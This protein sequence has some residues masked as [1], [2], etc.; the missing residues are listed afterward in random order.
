[1]LVYLL[2]GISPDIIRRAS[3]I[4]ASVSLLYL[5]CLIANGNPPSSNDV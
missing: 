3:T 2:A 4:A 5:G 1:M